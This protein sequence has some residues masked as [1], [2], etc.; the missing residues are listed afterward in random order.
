MRVGVLRG[1]DVD[2]IRGACRG[3]KKAADAFLQA[4]FVALQNVNAAIARLKVDGLGGIIFRG[5]LLE[6]GDE[7]DPEALVEDYER[8]YE[9]FDD[10]CHAINLP[11][12][13]ASG[14]GKQWSGV[15]DQ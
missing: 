5:G 9:F 3:A 14:E 11:K 12:A 4:V 13:A 6:H 2:A 1:F 7:R 8:A 10:R 15:R